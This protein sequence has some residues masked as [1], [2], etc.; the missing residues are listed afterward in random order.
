[1]DID[2]NGSVDLEEF[3]DAMMTFEQMSFG[4]S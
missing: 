1:M 3:A 2:R 4:F